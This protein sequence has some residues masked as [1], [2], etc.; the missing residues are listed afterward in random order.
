MRHQL[1]QKVKQTNCRMKTTSKKPNLFF[2]S[3]YSSLLHLP[4]VLRLQQQQEYKQKQR[5]R[6]KMKT[7]ARIAAGRGIYRVQYTTT[8]GRGLLHFEAAK[9]IS[10]R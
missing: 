2:I 9:A 7:R 1:N 5:E 3:H 8:P 4:V 10:V 6:E